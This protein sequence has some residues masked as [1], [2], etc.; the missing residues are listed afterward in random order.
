MIRFG[1]GVLAQLKQ[2]HIG[3]AF[4]QRSDTD[5]MKKTV[6]IAPVFCTVK[7][8]GTCIFMKGNK[9]ALREFINVSFRFTWPTRARWIMLC[10]ENNILF[11]FKHQWTDLRGVLH[12]RV[13]AIFICNRA[14]SSKLFRF[15]KWCSE[16]YF[17]CFTVSRV[18]PIFR[19]RY[20]FCRKSK[21][22][23]LINKIQLSEIN[24]TLFFCCFQLIIRN[25]IIF[26]RGDG[27]V[28][29]CTFIYGFLQQF[30]VDLIKN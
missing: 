25:I 21:S 4:N 19:Y 12:F 7:Y 24:I 29:K 23:W 26:I 10:S 28:L 30:Q 11:A 5:R 27:Y 13:F 1:Q 16:N 2:Q 9:R 15:C 22:N 18:F 8:R 6:Y 20:N 3:N 17:T 14:W